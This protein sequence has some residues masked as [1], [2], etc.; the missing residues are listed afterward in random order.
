M[1]IGLECTP[2]ILREKR[3]KQKWVPHAP[4]DVV[5]NI[6]TGNTYTCALMYVGS[7]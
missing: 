4:V 6:L 5:I 3:K 1:H 7:L 2:G